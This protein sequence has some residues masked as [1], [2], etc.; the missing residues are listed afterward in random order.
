M[1]DDTVRALRRALAHAEDYLGRLEAGPVAAGAGLEELRARLG[2][3]LGR[4]GKDPIEVIDALVEDSKGGMLGSAGGRFFAWVI[5]GSSPAALAADWLTSAWD[6]NAA[7]YACAPA[8]AVVEEV[9]GGWLKDLLGLPAESSFAFTTG[10]QLAHFVGL[11]AG[12][13]AV[14]RAAGWDVSEE[15]LFGAPPVRVLAGDQR[16]GSVDRALRY[17]GFGRKSVVPLL[18]DDD[19]RIEAAALE[20]ALEAGRSP[21]IV[22]LGAADLNIAA[23]DDFA[24]LIPIAKSAGAWVHVDGAFGLFARASASMR[25]LLE[26]VEG[27][28]SWATDAHKWLNVPFDCGLA[29]VRD[30]EAHRAAMTTSASYIAADKEARDQIDWNPEWS[31]RGR[32]FAVYAALRQLGRQGLEELIDRS[33]RF[34]CALVDGIGSLPGAQILWRPVLNQGLVRFPDSRPGSSAADHD[35]RTEAVIAAVN[36]TGEAFFS[37]TTWRGMRAMRVSVVNWR[38]TAADVDR[39]IAAVAKAILMRRSK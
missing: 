32:G 20:R 18:T 30:P 21:A 1:S 8:E 2:G 17:L 16:H 3:E 19:G 38:T 31:R 11:A 27:A 5:G 37:G 4:E 29:F 23:F 24:R 12:R 34:A 35:A 7:L 6:Q 39:T 26:G 25:H 13:L 9:A 14:L 22:A 15:G 10:C 28:D 33:C 36:A